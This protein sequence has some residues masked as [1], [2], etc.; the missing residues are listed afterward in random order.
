MGDF[1]MITIKNVKTLDDRIIQIK[2]ASSFEHTIDANGKLLLPGLIDS[3]ISFGSP[4]EE[5]WRLAVEFAIRGGVT[6]VIDIPTIDFPSDSK[7]ELEQKRHL[8][9]RQLSEVKI[10][11]NFLLYGKGNSDYIEEMGIQKK[12]IVGSLILL[13][14]EHYGLDERKWDSIFQMAAWEDLPIAINS[15]RENSW[16]SAKFKKLDESLLE[17]AIYYAERQNTRLYVLNVASQNELDLIYQARER[18]LMIYAETTLH[19]LFPQERGQAD[20]LWDAIN[21]GAIETIGSGYQAKEQEQEKLLV[22][23]SDFDFLNPIFIL[24]L[25]FSA[26][27]D[28]KITLENIVHLTKGSLYD[29]FELDRENSDYVL[30]DLEEEHIAK[31]VNKNNFI[32]LKLKGWPVYTIIKGQIFTISR[33]R[34]HLTS[35]E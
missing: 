16:E 9:D 22:E 2:I 14:S 32:E 28:G 15:H 4:L 23:G 21:R 29:I 27:Q 1:L 24:P 34:Y 31:K 13:T 6:T 35:L 12:L 8:V 17:K 20:F 26:Y 7:A 25:L 5:N 30:I 3:H 10:P 33:G 19:H 11:L 18:S